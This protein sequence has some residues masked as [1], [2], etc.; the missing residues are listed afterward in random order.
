MSKRVQNKSD[1]YRKRKIWFWIIL[2]LIFI[3]SVLIYFLLTNVS[4]EKR[5]IR[6][7]AC[8]CVK[9]RAVYTMR[10]G[11]DMAMLIRVANGFTLNA[12]VTKVNLDRIVKNDS[13]YHIPCRGNSSAS[14]RMSF[15]NEINRKIR[16]S[17]TRLTDE[18]VA[19]SN[20]KPIKSYS[21]L[22]VGLPAVFVLINYYPEFHRINFVH[23][24]HSS[25]F[26][27]SEY[28]VIDMFFVLDIYPT[29]RIIERSLK[30]KIDFY[31]VQDRFNFIDLIDMIGGVN[32]TI[33]EPY[34]EE[35][36]LRAGKTMLDGYYA[37]EY[38]R[39]VDWRNIKMQV[40]SEKRKD[41][42][43]QDNFA[44]DPQTMEML[45]EMRN[46]RQ[47]QVLEGMRNSFRNLPKPDQLRVVDNFKN[48]FRT[49][50]SPDFLIKLYSDILVSLHF[51][52]GSLPGYYSKEKDKL[53]FYPDLPAFERLKKSEIRR[54]L[55]V[56]KG[57]TQVIY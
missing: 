47:R 2:G 20:D 34:A 23:I 53:F 7:G 32:I 25:I 30:Q 55:E 41:L 28:R 18:V 43:R 56:R 38:I 4:T 42:V 37:W 44:I 50:M 17:Y 35:Y 21:I 1:I 16:A 49:D 5:Y 14:L 57:K 36:K 11:S 6:V 54:Y 15:V 48:V 10:E 19:E 46:Q 8:G 27:N 45:Y 52:Y 9:Q 24:P 51:S 22:Y 29:M 33:D 31:M 3:A 39:F 13:V 12:D 26:L 40:K